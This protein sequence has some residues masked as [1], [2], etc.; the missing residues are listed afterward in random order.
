MQKCPFCK[1]EIHLKELPHQGF[2]NNYRVCPSCEEK[3]TVDRKTKKRQAILIVIALISL[4]FTILLYLKG[5]DWLIPSV[6]SY[7]IIGVLIY[8]ANKRVFLVPYKNTQN[9]NN[10][11]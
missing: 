8:W 1:C 11:T 10:N 7:I 4:T 3:F 9:F 5:T 6:I 2:F